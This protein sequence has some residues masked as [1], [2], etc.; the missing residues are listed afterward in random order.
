MFSLPSNR[1]CTSA[2]VTVHLQAILADAMYRELFMHLPQGVRA[3]AAVSQQLPRLA[4]SD[5][6]E[7]VQ[8]SAVM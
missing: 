5:V 4:A 1:V 6:L 3:Q 8:Q 7:D 2:Q